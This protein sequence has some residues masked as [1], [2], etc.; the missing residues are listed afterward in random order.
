MAGVPIAGRCGTR[1][2]TPVHRPPTP[3]GPH[4]PENDRAAQLGGRRQYPQRERWCV[5]SGPM[6]SSVSSHLVPLCAL[7]ISLALTRPAMCMFSPNHTI[8]SNPGISGHIPC[9][10]SLAL[11]PASLRLTSSPQLSPNPHLIAC[12]EGPPLNSRRTGVRR[13]L[14]RGAQSPQTLVSFPGL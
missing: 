5:K 1:P 7:R 4:V 11:P 14:M 2:D 12:H 10:L 13:H 3:P 8:R 9:R 6:S